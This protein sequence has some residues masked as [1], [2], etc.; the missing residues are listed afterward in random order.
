VRAR[1]LAVASCALVFV[2]CGGQAGPNPTPTPTATPVP[3]ATP[4]PEPLIAAAGDIACG[5]DRAG[6]PCRHLE[7]SDLIIRIGEEH[8]RLA[9]VLPLGDLQYNFGF[10]EEFNRFYDPSWGRFKTL[11]RPV[12]GNHEY[13]AGPPS[14]YFD[15]WNGRNAQNG[16][17]GQRGLGYY[18][19][20]LGAWHLV[21]LNS[22]CRE[23]PGG[24]CQA[25]SAQERWLKTDLDQNARPCTLAYWHH[26]RFTSGQ[27]QRL[28]PSP[29]LLEPL[30]QTLYDQGADVILVA[31][32]HFYERF[33]PQTPG[34][35]A[36]ARRGIRQFT[37]GT[38]GR[39]LYP[40]ESIAR[41]S[42][43]RYNVG[44]GVLF[45]ELRPRSYAWKFVGVDAVAGHPDEGEA[46]CH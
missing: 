45:M 30:W 28:A 16:V 13:E 35:Q 38:G 11:S 34:G 12:L 36:D 7:T 9:A 43:M 25:G 2:H 37:V 26:P 3:A 41:N 6:L 10:L 17:A 42:E 5:A 32:D 8:G 23:V 31:H 19:F 44:F 27:S 29:A 24:G 18:S 46:D 15:Y 21:A 1:T 40:F 14:G 4:V 22:N 39:D 33:A 20:N